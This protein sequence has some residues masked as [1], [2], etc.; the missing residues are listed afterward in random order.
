[1]QSSDPLHK[2]RASGG[3]LLV[4]LAVRA[5]MRLLTYA[6]HRV[7]APQPG[8]TYDADPFERYRMIDGVLLGLEN[9]L[10]LVTMIVF[11]VWI[12]RTLKALRQAGRETMSPG[13]AVGGWFIPL[14][15]VVLP[16]L[17]VRSALRAVRNTAPLA[18]IWW[19]VWL[20]NMSLGTTHQL[21]RQLALVPE[22]YDVIPMDLLDTLFDSLEST[23]WPWVIA[24]TAAWG[25]LAL[26]VATVRKSATPAS[27]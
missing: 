15:N 4:L 17:S 12:Y 27:T 18:G 1:M 8:G 2:V 5:S 14:A 16:W 19:L 10:S 13:L 9:V 25:L 26:I 23:F 7:T 20:V 3:V 21:A 6:V 24:D 11:F 22:L